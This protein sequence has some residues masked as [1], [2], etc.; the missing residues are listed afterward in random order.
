MSFRRFCSNPNGITRRKFEHRRR[1]AAV[2]I[3]KGDL[4]RFLEIHKDG[5]KW[6]E[7]V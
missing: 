7:M 6:F 3:N 5:L 4:A 2:P 1:M